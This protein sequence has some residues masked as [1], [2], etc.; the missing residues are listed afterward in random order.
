MH[1]R[2]LKVELER[3]ILWKNKYLRKG[4]YSDK[5]ISQPKLQHLLLLLHLSLWLLH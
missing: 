1:L 5:S 4:F 3:E 2:F